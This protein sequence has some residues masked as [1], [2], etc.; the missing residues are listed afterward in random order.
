MRTTLLPR[1]ITGRKFSFNVILTLKSPPAPP[2]GS[3]RV[4]QLRVRPLSKVRA[5]ADRNPQ[6][7]LSGARHVSHNARRLKQNHSRLLVLQRHVLFPVLTRLLVV[8]LMRMLARYVA[9]LLV[10]AHLCY[11]VVLAQAQ[12]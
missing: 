4:G 11:K 12:S 5:A 3:S 7:I 6:P 9:D 10:L 2:H 8:A 1:V